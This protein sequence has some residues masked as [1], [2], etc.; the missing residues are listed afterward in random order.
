MEYNKKNIKDSDNENND[1]DDENNF[2]KIEEIIYNFKNDSD[3][4]STVQKLQKYSSKNLD[5]MLDLL[6][7][8]SVENIKNSKTP[9][10]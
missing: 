1:D 10:S 7:Y 2:D 9:I 4:V 5:N 8:C 6:L 3:Y